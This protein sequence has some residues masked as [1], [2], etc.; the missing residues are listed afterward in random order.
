MDPSNRDVNEVIIPRN[1]KIPAKFST[2]ASTVQDNQKTVL[3]Q[4]TQGDD[5]N[6]DYVV[7]IGSKEIPLPPYP[8]GSPLGIAYAYDIDQ[9]VF[10]EVTDLTT[11]HSLGT[12]E[13]DRL[14]NLTDEQLESA[15]SKVASLSVQ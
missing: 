14:A 10:V 6:P 5:T 11:N 7:E 9:T 12:F 4:V 13:V 2:S 1:T 3:V 8:K 15:T